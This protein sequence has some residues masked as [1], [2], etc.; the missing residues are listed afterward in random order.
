[1][2]IG[3]GIATRDMVECLLVSVKTIQVALAI[4]GKG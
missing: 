4:S 3:A 2:V 1:M